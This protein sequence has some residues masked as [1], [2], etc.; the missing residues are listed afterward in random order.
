MEPFCTPQEIVLMILIFGLL[1]ILIVHFF[2]D[3]EVG[4]D[5]YLLADRS[6]DW[7]KAA[8]SIAVSWI[9]APAI[10]IASLQSYTKGIAGAF[11]FIF[12]N[13]LCFFVFAPVAIKLRKRIPLGYS[14]PDYISERYQG[15]TLVHISF[16]LIF[17]SY[18]LG[19]IVINSVAGGMLLNQLSGIPVTLAILIMPTIAIA[20]SFKTGMRASVITDIFQM[21][22]ILVVGGILIPW[23]FMASGGLTTLMSGIGGESGE[24]SNILHPAIA[25]AFGIPMTIGLITG[26]LSDQMFFQRAFSV[27]EKDIT[28]AFVVG[29]LLFAIVPV[30]LCIPG[31]IAAA[32]PQINVAN[33][34]MVAPAVIAYYLPHSAL[35]LFG[36]M[37]LCGLCSTLDSSFCAISSL[38]AIDIYKKY[39]REKPSSEQLLKV[40]RR[41]MLVFTIIGTALALLQPKLIWLSLIYGSL[42]GA[43]FFPLLFSLYARKISAKTLSFAI[44]ISLVSSIPFSIYANINEN[45]DLIVASA[46]LS[47]FS[48]L[49]V[50]L[51][52]KT[53]FPSK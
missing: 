32:N 43:G 1:M 14:F 45:T 30:L 25:F 31:F 36:V 38:G 26:P 28:K 39:I 53:L 21:L 18:Q 6:L 47:V 16:L 20:Y 2:N 44:I 3:R 8:I 37:A 15:N 23:V 12:P 51:F 40:S 4:A 52:G 33:P 29:G 22:F 13:V 9:W 48:G 7:R 34:E 10:F 49:L 17:L 42:A 46:L 19:S 24:F 50:L 11:W 27:K 41:L 35:L 5:E